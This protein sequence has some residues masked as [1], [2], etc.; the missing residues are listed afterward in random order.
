MI[1]RIQSVYLGS[2]AAAIVGMLLTGIVS[3]GR[4]L[5]QWVTLTLF[6]SAAFAATI[7]IFMYK[8]RNKQRLVVV[9]AQVCTVFSA[10]ILYA[11]LYLDGEL[12]VRTAAGFAW[13]RLI[14]VTL[15]LLAYLFFM[16]ARRAIIRDIRLVRSMNRLR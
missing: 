15:P 9:A 7:A 2:G 16:L 3:E 6:V 8:T 1:Q 13:S 4:H 12:Y 11:T 5:T 10:A 14:A